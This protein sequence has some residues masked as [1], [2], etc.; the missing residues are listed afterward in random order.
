MKREQHIYSLR[1]TLTRILVLREEYDVLQMEHAAIIGTPGAQDDEELQI[2]IK[3][4]KTNITSLRSE[5]EG[6]TYFSDGRQI[7]GLAG[8][9]AQ[10]RDILRSYM[11]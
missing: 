11:H 8:T 3:E 6:L 5:L 10:I 7:N 9:P 4:L 2:R 1:E